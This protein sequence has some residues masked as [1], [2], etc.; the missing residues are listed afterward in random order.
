MNTQR[1]ILTYRDVSARTGIRVPAL[2]KRLCTGTMPKPD[3]RV[4]GSPVWF[5]ESLESW[6]TTAAPNARPQNRR[7]NKK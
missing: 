3:L 5:P 4:G 1:P 7:E 2:R 6:L